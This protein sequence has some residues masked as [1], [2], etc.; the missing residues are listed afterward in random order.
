MELLDTLPVPRRPRVGRR[1]RRRLR[2]RLENRHLVAVAGEHH[3]RAHADHA[4]AAD[5]NRAHERLLRSQERPVG[6]ADTGEDAATL[7]R[8]TSARVLDAVGTVARVGL[9]AVWLVSGLLKA[10]DPDGTYVAVRAYDVLPRAGVAVMAGVLPLLEIGARPPVARR[11]PRPARGGAVGGAAA[12]VRRGCDAGLGP[13]AVDRLRLLRRWR[14]RRAGG[15]GIRAR[16]PAR[17][18]VPAAGRLARGAAAHAGRTR[19]PRQRTRETV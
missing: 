4:G 13:R 16:A 1:R 7:G 14:R 3:C 11:V 6:C 8:V 10:L 15:D 12:G 9:A 5:H 17:C 18:R 2:I 19:R